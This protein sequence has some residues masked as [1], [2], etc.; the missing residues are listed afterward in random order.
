MTKL[1]CSTSILKFSLFIITR[2]YMMKGKILP[3]ITKSYWVDFEK[4]S[5]VYQFFL[6][7]IIVCLIYNMRRHASY[8]W[9]PPKLCSTTSNCSNH[10]DDHISIQ[11][12]Y[13]CSSHHPFTARLW[14]TQQIDLLQMCGSCNFMQKLFESYSCRRLSYF[15]ISSR[16]SCLKVDSTI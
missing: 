15:V 13:F 2:Y 14:W 6:A 11:N 3:N 8:R 16:P 10:C 12:L 1:V 4:L 7:A 5:S 9:P